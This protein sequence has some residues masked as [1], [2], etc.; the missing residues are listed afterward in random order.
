VFQGRGNQ[1][2]VDPRFTDLRARRRTAPSLSGTSERAYQALR[3]ETG[4]KVN[5]WHYGCV[6]KTVTDVERD[7]ALA[8]KL[9]S[10]EILSWEADYI[11][12]RLNKEELQRAMRSLADRRME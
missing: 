11:D 5:L 2:A 4:G 8:G 3:K 6:P 7:L 1:E 9:G 12:N 10:R